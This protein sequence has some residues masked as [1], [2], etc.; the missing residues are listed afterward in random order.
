MPIDVTERLQFEM[1][2][3]QAA[4]MSLAGEFAAGLAHEIKNPLTGKV[5][6]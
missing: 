6:N 4:Q 5:K 3:H 1:E 2:L